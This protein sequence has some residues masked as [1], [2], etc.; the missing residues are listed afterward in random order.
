MSSDRRSGDTCYVLQSRLG[1]VR[2]QTQ[3]RRPQPTVVCPGRVGPDA[4]PASQYPSPQRFL[5]RREKPERHPHHT[6][7]MN[8]KAWSFVCS[9][10]SC[11][12][13]LSRPWVS[14]QNISTP[15]K[16]HWQGHRVCIL[17]LSITPAPGREVR[18]S[19][20]TTDRFQKRQ[21]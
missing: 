21:P 8:P 16:W 3:H 15:G 9:Y 2:R 17:V 13:I 4:R 6:S 7:S 18:K 20:Y 5:R 19:R 14:N 11:Q 10:L 1:R 12:S